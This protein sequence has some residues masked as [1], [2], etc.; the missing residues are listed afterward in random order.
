L[1]SQSAAG[2]AF[3]GNATKKG[4]GVVGDVKSSYTVCKGFVVDGT[5]SH[6]GKISTNLTLTDVAPGLKATVSGDVPDIASGKLALQFA[7]DA[8][9]LKADLG[10]SAAPKIDISG[11]VK[12][13]AVSAGADLGYDSAK[14]AVTK[15][16]FAASYAASDFTVAASLAD[17]LDTLKISY[18]QAFNPKVTVGAE[19][20]RKLASGANSFALGV[21]SKLEGGASAKGVIDNKGLLS[22]LYTAPLQS[23]TTITFSSQ[24]DTKALDKSAKVG[25]QLAFKA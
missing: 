25:V 12:A 8:I 24:V 3:T 5:L 20:T 21:S 23:K 9:G 7:K 14:G 2:V 15:Y 11:A 18:V 1:A 10:L 22:I 6:A 19:V 13:G 16:S 17:K 4:E